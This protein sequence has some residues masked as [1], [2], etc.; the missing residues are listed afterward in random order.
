[1]FSVT[2]LKERIPFVIE[3]LD[4]KIDVSLYTTIN[5]REREKELVTVE[6]FCIIYLNKVVEKVYKSKDIPTQPQVIQN[7]T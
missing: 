4:H 6:F 5:K 1:M 7:K 2:L 3:L